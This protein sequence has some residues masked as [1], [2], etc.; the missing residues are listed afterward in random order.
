MHSNNLKLMVHTSKQPE[1]TPDAVH[2]RKRPHPFIK[3]RLSFHER[4][5]R[6]SMLACALLLGILSL[7]NLDAP[8]AKKAAG[9]IERAL[10]MEINL[11]QSLGQ[12]SFVRKI[13]PESALVFLNLS[14][15][16]ATPLP[17]EGALTH[18]YSEDQPWQ[19]YATRDDA[20][21]YACAEGIVAAVSALSDGSFGVLI[22]H[23]EGL[24]SVTA[25]LK[26]VSI[27][28]G[29]KVQRGSAIGTSGS[30]LYYELRQNG[31]ACNP[32]EKFKL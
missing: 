5:L 7:G 18:A 14:G 17:V 25:C 20:P 12:L 28:S 9:G 2:T 24:E 10:T 30:S 19:M 15:K 8:W 31:E 11:D 23:G 6:N 3:T 16:D 32:E 29:S 22:D 26:S 13:M 4:L 27:A 21:V 1:N